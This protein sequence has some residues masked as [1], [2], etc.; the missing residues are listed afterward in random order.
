MFVGNT[1]FS[2]SLLERKSWKFRFLWSCA[3]AAEFS[4]TFYHFSRYLI[5]SE[6]SAVVLILFFMVSCLKYSQVWHLVLA[7][8]RLT[9]LISCTSHGMLLF[10]FK[11][12]SLSTDTGQKTIWF[13]LIRDFF[14][15]TSEKSE[16]RGIFVRL[17]KSRKK[18]RIMFYSIFCQ[19]FL[20]TPDGRPFIYW[21]LNA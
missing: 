15:W 7:K 2:A 8:H 16:D 20:Q 3:W 5:K 9:G 19:F 14:W 11:L 13:I 12:P 6:L 10:L 18:S 17:W 1:A 4:R 21:W